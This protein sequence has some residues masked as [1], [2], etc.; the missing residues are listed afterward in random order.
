[1][2]ATATRDELRRHLEHAERWDSSAGDDPLFRHCSDLLLAARGLEAAASAAGADGLNPAVLGCFGAALDS[3]GTV[4]LLLDRA[5]GRMHGA[6][7][8]KTASPTRP[9]FCLPSTRTCALPLMLPNSDER[10]LPAQTE[11]HG[12]GPVSRCHRGPVAADGARYRVKAGL[13]VGVSAHRP[14]NLAQ[15]S[16]LQRAALANAAV[17]VLAFG[18]LALSPVTISAPIRLGELAILGAGLGAML[19]INL[20]LVRRALAPLEDL[21]EET[22]AVDLRDPE[23]QFEP[24][25]PKAPSSSPSPAPSTPWSTHLPTNDASAPAL[26]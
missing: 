7:T 17:L 9:V 11:S 22:K 20:I 2:N 13:V 1:M 4:C 16:L 14:Q 24:R 26:P 10:F 18:L 5:R 8:A 19:V 15:L 12:R 6:A 21:A 3:L 25:R 23:P